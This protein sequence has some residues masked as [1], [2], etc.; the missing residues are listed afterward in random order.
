MVLIQS[1]SKQIKESVL[2]Q[3]PRFSWDIRYVP[4]NGGKGNQEEYVDAV[5]SWSLFHD[6]LYYSNSNKVPANLRKIMLQ[7]HLFGCAIDLCKHLL[8]EEIESDE[9][10]EKYVDLI[11]EICFYFYK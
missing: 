4:W 2:T 1:S 10:V 11:Q 3:R 9:T 6:K 8:F 5:K 7:S